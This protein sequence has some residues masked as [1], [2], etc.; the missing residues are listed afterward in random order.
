MEMALHPMTGSHIRLFQYLLLATSVVALS[1]IQASALTYTRED[2]IAITQE[3]YVSV[4]GVATGDT[5]EDGLTEIVAAIDWYAP[6]ISDGIPRILFYEYNSSDDTYHVTHAIMNAAL[7]RLTV[8]PGRT[9]ALADADNDGHVDVSFAGSVDGS[10]GVFVYSWDGTNYTKLFSNPGIYEEVAVGD[11][12]GDGASELVVSAGSI[13]EVFDLL[14][15]AL[16]SS[17]AIPCYARTS[18]V[19]IVN[20]DLDPSLEIV[21]SVG[22]L[23]VE[24]FQWTG[25]QYVLEHSSSVDF[26]FASCGMGVGDVDN[27]TA[28]EVVRFDYWRNIVVYSWDGVGPDVE[29]NG[30]STDDG[31]DCVGCGIVADADNDGIPEIVVG[32]DNLVGGKS[33]LVFELNGTGYSRAWDSGWVPGYVY[34]IC[35]GDPD[36][37]GIDELVTGSGSQSKVNVFE[38]SP[39]IVSSFTVSPGIGKAEDLFVFDASAAFAG[40]D[41]NYPLR[42][43]WDWNN[44]GQWDT[45]FSSEKTL[46]HEFTEGNYTVVMQVANSLGQTNQTFR[47]VVVDD[48]PPVITTDLVDGAVLNNTYLTLMW[49]AYDSLAGLASVTYSLDGGTAVSPTVSPIVFPSLS[50]G[51]H[52]LSLKATDKAG[53]TAYLNL[54]FEVEKSS[55]LGEV[56]W[57]GLLAGVAAA[58]LFVAVLFWHDKSSRK[59][60]SPPP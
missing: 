41:P 38:V 29:W 26:G 32:H 49:S 60:P 56:F 44:D 37:D 2:T 24:A 42:V 20:A 52:E 13:V 30:T 25:T 33:L 4:W 9:I 31:S 45:A 21:V 39:A 53:N 36:Y 47:T 40:S 12:D 8:G 59:G 43:R 48:A 14:N 28:A 27:D 50:K 23:D 35:L 11:A 15:G 58:V 19:G 5:D 51:H 3:T 55:E 54:T 17:V 22:D 34:S 6:W 7:S 16:M 46:S 57:Y 18:F 10:D 1:S